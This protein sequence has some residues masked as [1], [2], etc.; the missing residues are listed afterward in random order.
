MLDVTRAVINTKADPTFLIAWKN[1]FHPD[2]MQILANIQPYSKKILIV[3]GWH[4]PFLLYRWAGRTVQ[5]RTGPDP[6]D[7]SAW[8]E[9]WMRKLETFS[10]SSLTCWRSRPFSRSEE[11]LLLS[12]LYGFYQEGWGGGCTVAHSIKFCNF[13]PDKAL[14]SD[15]RHGS[16]SRNNMFCTPALDLLKHLVCFPLDAH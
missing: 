10:Q 3:N 5:E 1:F 14:C 15:P 11:D 12:I 8:W 4:K 13:R 16:H 9:P 2:F 6:W 7:R